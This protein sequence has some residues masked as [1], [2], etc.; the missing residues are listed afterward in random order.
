MKKEVTKDVKK[1]KTFFEKS[2]TLG[3]EELSLIRGG[4]GGNVS[5]DD[6]EG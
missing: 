4:D 5:T 1:E 2:A 6:D 3:E